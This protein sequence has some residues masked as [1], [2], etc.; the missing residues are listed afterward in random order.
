MDAVLMGFGPARTILCTIGTRPEAIKLAPLVKVFQKLA[1]VRCRVLLTGQHRELVDQVLQFFGV[2]PDIDLNAMRAARPLDQ[3]AH[4]LVEAVAYVIGREQPDMVLAQ[5]DTTSVLATAMASFRQGVPFAHVEAGLRTGRLFAPFPE[6]ANRV[7]ASHLGAIH[8]APTAGARENLERE[9]I[10]P[11]RIFVTG[12]TVIDALLAT[13]RRSVPIGVELDPAKRLV[14]VTAHRRESFGE[15]LQQICG[16]IREL[17][18]RH[19]EVEFLWPVHPNPAVAPVVQGLLAGLSRVRLCRPLPYGSFVSA[20]ARATLI[21]TDSGGV[22]EEA[23]ALGKPVLVMRQESERPEAIE[24]GVARLVGSDAATI[25]EETTRLLHDPE[26]YRSM[27]RGM[28]PFGDGRAA[29]RIAQIVGWHLG[30]SGWSSAAPPRR[31]RSAGQLDL[32]KQRR[33][34]ATRR[35]CRDE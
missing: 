26:A 27:A 25:V 23:P 20:M 11:R 24:C 30:V 29:R 31:N 19:P 4:D 22:Q 32:G 14:L 2:K 13:A 16:A 1:G 17:H 15:P 33:R 5:G 35:G 10:D 18:D 8:F 12:N 28:S 7:V 6:E 3:W 21:L 9:G 34:L